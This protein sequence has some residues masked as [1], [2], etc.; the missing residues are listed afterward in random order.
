MPSINPLGLLLKGR[1]RRGLADFSTG[2]KGP[3]DPRSYRATQQAGA[4]QTPGKGL[5]IDT[6][7]A[8][9]AKPG[10]TSLLEAVEAAGEGE[11]P[12]AAVGV[13]EAGKIPHALDR[14]A[15]SLSI[16]NDATELP[17]YSFIVPAGTLVNDRMLRLRLLGR[18]NNNSGAPRTC[19]IRVK[20]AGTVVYND[21][22]DPGGA[23]ILNIGNDRLFTVDMVWQALASSASQQMWGYIT[24]TNGAPPTVGHGTLAGNVE[25]S[26][27]FGSAATAIDMSVPVT[28]E[29][30]MQMS[31]ASLNFNWTRRSALLEVY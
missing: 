10:P 25:L 5:G 14:N 24:L 31:F 21:P 22:I 13:A 19:R 2:P 23:G 1:P 26:M 17:F 16:T 4:P 18:M 6:K 8:L 9:E 12:E 20:L 11:K 29:V 30:T 7:G 3:N 27:P 15:T 28:L